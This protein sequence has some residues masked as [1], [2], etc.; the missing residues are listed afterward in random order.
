M[1]QCWLAHPPTNVH[2]T[3]AIRNHNKLQMAVDLRFE[4]GYTLYLEQPAMR[5]MTDNELVL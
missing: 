1:N 3:I 2:P 5:L 4:S